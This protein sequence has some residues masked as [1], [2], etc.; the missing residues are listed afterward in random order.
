MIPVTRTVLFVCVA[1]AARS[2]MAEGYANARY[3]DRIRAHSAG[4]VPGRLSSHAVRAMAEMGIDISGHRSKSL[5]EFEGREM[6]LLV[7]LCDQGRCPV[8]P[9]AKETIHQEFPDPSGFTGTDEEI[10]DGFRQVRDEIC[11]WIDM[12]WGVK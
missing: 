5:D 10:M 1:N 6:D 4:L 8:F 3:G 2:Q 9:W 11:A 12:T 7:T